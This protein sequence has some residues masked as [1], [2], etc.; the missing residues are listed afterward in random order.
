[1]TGLEFLAAA[2]LSGGIAGLTGWPLRA[3][4]R[5]RPDAGAPPPSPDLPPFAGIYP[6]AFASHLDQGAFGEA[7]TVMMM[8]AEG[9]RPINGKP[10]PGPQGI[11]GIF[12]RRETGGWRAVLIETKTNTSP[13]KPAAMSDEKVLGDLDA[14]YL[15]AGDARLGEVYAAISSALQTGDPCVEKQLWRHQLEAG[16]TLMDPLSSKGQVL[17]GRSFRP[18]KTEMEALMAAVG[19]LDRTGVILARSS[20]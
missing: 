10:G 5:L 4:A 13:Y 14:L 16:R 1:M 8:A 12:F 20:R 3:L 19:E 17:P 7:L 9:W 18:V 11:D 6:S 2:G 15:T